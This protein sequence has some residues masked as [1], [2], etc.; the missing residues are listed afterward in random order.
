MAEPIPLHA[1]ADV[2]H[3][4]GSPWS[5]TRGRCR[6]SGNSSALAG[7]LRQGGPS[8]SG[9]VLKRHGPFVAFNFYCKIKMYAINYTY[10][11]VK[12][13]KICFMYHLGVGNRH[14][15]GCLTLFTHQ[16]RGVFETVVG[17]AKSPE[18]NA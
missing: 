17:V 18:G 11:S 8:P 4:G 13:V 16:R 12:P 5:R 9:A 3:L 10:Y 15:K 14:S 1:A 7:D 6:S 2:L